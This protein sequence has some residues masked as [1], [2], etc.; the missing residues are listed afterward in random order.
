MGNVGSNGKQRMTRQTYALDSVLEFYRTLPFSYREFTAENADVVRERDLA[1]MYPDLPPLLE[2]KPRVLDVGCGV[3]TFA[4]SM[5]HHHGCPVVGID[6]NPVAIERAQTVAREVGLG[7]EFLTADLFLYDPLALFDLVVCQGVLHHTANCL[8]GVKRILADLVKPGGHAFIGLYHRY[9]RRAFIEHFDELRRAGASED[10]MFA[11]YREL[12]SQI[13]NV[14]HSRSWFRDQVLHPHETHHT[15]AEMVPIMEETGARLV[16]T[17]INRF[18]RIASLGALLDEEKA[19]FDVGRHRIAE[20][21]YYPGFFTFM[22]RK[23]KT[24]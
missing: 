16:S 15:L 1:R 13:S 3:G 24:G 18:A 20:G 19:L 4:N 2:K 12:H 8:A 21:R 17:S 5:S 6:F 9:G 7:A 10:K 23:V 14:A 22:C 11:R